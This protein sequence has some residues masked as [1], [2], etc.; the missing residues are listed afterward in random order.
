MLTYH[1]LKAGG[2]N[3]G[4]GGNIGKSFAW[5]VAVNDFDVYVTD[6]RA[7]IMDKSYTEL[8]SKT[9]KDTK[10]E[11]N[12]FGIDTVVRNFKINSKIFQSQSSMIA[13]AAS[14]KLNL[15]GVNSSTQD[16]FNKGL[17]SRLYEEIT[18]DPTITTKETEEQDAL[19][20]AESTLKLAKYLNDF[21]IM[22]TFPVPGESTSFA[23]TCL[24]SVL[25]NVNTDVN[26][27][28]VIP[29]NTEIIMD[30]IAGIAIG[31]VF[32]INSSMLP[33]EYHRRDLGF[34]VT[35]LKQTVEGSNWLT[36]CQDLVLES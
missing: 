12:I 9:G 30:G 24:K 26:Y 33:K 2:L 4:L 14:G 7:V 10:F 13:I 28:S 16:Y 6:S 20:Y 8:P 36:T 27:R 15:G 11:L 18:D 31:E 32:R 22:Q 3:V 25:L 34:I 1:L 19:K 21:I 29:I 17:Q 35:S 5:Q 23:N